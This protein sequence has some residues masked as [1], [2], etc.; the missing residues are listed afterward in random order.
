[1]A[2][3][4]LTTQDNSLLYG[5]YELNMRAPY[6]VRVGGKLFLETRKTNTLVPH[7]YLLGR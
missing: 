4:H 2:S 6:Q 5:D 7:H 3:D 1:M